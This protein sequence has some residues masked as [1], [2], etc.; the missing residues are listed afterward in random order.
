MLAIALCGMALL[1][2]LGVQWRYHK[3]LHQDQT[4]VKA[5]ALAASVMSRSEAGLRTNFD[6]VQA[7][8]RGAAEATLDPNGVFE[9][10]ILENYED[11][12][13]NLKKVEVVV[14]WE[15]DRGPQKER[16]WCIFLRGE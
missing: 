2:V 3:S 6:G 9:Y 4:R 13:G 14:H 5:R 1:A 7:L 15:S 16:L 11:A 12:E 8:S 10:E